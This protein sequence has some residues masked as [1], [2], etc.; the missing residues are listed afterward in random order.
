MEYEDSVTQGA[1]IPLDT[2]I[3]NQVKAMDLLSQKMNIIFLIISCV[4]GPS[5]TSSIW[6]SSSPFFYA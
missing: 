5:D 6:Y 4:Y 3:E 1:I 2:W